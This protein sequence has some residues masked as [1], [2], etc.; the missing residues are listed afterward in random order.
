MST[1]KKDQQVQDSVS[2]NEKPPVD[3]DKSAAV[4]T[5]DGSKKP[6]FGLRGL[7]LN[8]WV[9]VACITA[10][11]LFGVYLFPLSPVTLLLTMC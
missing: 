1:I 2:L 3:Q 9:N 4:A 7:A 6:Y 11:C 8:I 5:D 10:M